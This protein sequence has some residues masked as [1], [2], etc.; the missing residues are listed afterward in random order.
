MHHNQP[1]DQDENSVPSPQQTFSTLRLRSQRTLKRHRHSPLISELDQIISKFAREGSCCSDT[2]LAKLIDNSL[3]FVFE[4]SFKRL[5]VH[6]ICEYYNLVSYSEG[7]P[8]GIRTTFVQKRPFAPHPPPQ[9]T[10]HHYLIT[11]DENNCE[12]DCG[13][14]QY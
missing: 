9:T 10:L 4:H 13:Y 1:P 7:D 14:L 2:V 11:L 6:A 3:Q 12:Q 8:Q 5:L